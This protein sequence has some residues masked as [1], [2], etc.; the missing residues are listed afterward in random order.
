MATDLPASEYR[1]LSRWFPT[2]TDR[3]RALGR[4]RE[5]LTSWE[6]GLLACQVK[7]STARRVM[8]VAS[9]AADVEE[10]VGDARGVGRWMLAPQPQFRGKTPVEMIAAGR[11]NELSQVVYQAENITAPERTVRRSRQAP[12][13]AVD[14]PRRRER[15]R[16]ADEAAVLVRIGEDADLIGPITPS[17]DRNPSI[18]A[19]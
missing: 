16:A 4:S 7:P 17:A 19:K 11:L 3:A 2:V 9:V 15:A 13:N 1:E 10:L 12:R 8:H 18:S 5:T 6:R 14:F